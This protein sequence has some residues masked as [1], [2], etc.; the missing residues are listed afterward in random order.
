MLFNNLPDDK[1]YRVCLGTNTN[2]IE[3][4]CIGI[5]RV[6]SGV[7]GVYASADELPKWLQER[8]AVLMVTDW[9]PPTVSVASI[10]RRIDKNT[11]WVVHP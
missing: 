9:R 5:D 2:T 11:F 4:A 10:G 3:V 7:D 1:L 6:D 8:L